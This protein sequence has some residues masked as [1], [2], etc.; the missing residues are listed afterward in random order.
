MFYLIELFVNLRN[1][2]QLFCFFS[3][4][5]ILLVYF[6]IYLRR[7]YYSLHFS[8]FRQRFRLRKNVGTKKDNFSKL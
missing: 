2:T 1:I 6:F 5:I 7:Q 3:V 4:L 8:K